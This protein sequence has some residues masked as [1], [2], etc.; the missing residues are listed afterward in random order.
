MKLMFIVPTM[1]LLLMG[2]GCASNSSSDT[3]EIYDARADGER[4]LA[5]TLA[6]A[7]RLNK[8]VLLNL[9]ASWCNDSQ[10]MFALFNTNQEI[11]RVI[12]ENYVFE[13]IDVNDRGAGARNA[14]LVERLGNP[15]D[16]GIPVL[17]ILNA[18]GKILNDDSSERLAD[19]AHQHPAV[20]LAYL[21]KWSG[22]PTPPR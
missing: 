2:A 1:G 18:D 14:P 15:L 22:R 11:A 16:R 21:R 9:G 3:P 6:E 17:L 20:V 4:Q 8:R 10:A 5:T 12:D 7:K 19:S 13:M